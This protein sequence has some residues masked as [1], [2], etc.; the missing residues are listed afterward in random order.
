MTARSDS[1]LGRQSRFRGWRLFV[2]AALLAFVLLLI[3]R[4]FFLEVYMIP[5]ESM[6]PYLEP[7]DRII[8]NRL[9]GEVHRGDVVVF[10]GEGSFSPYVSASPWLTDPVGTGAQWLG[11]EGSDTIYVKRVIGVAGDRVE[12]CS[13]GH[14]KVNGRVLE[15]SYLYPGNTASETE[16]SVEVPADRMWVMGDHRSVSRDSRALLGAPGGGMIRTEKVIGK[17]I[18]IALPADRAGRLGH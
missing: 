13:D 17:P 4:H 7:G 9:A 18:F 15:E 16:F 2:P 12:C 10:D 11:L 1:A 3:I 5:S 14:L 8:V 6:E